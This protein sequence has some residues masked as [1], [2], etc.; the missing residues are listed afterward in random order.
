MSG[1]NF[2]YDCSSLNPEGRIYQVEY[3]EKAVESSST[4]VGVVCSDGIILGTEKIVI[5]KMMISGTDKRVYSI[6]K[7]VGSV[8]NGLTPDGRALMFRAREEAKQYHDNFGIKIP[9]SILAERVAGVCQMNTLY[10]GRRPY[11]ASIIFATHDHL[12]G[13]TLWMVEPSGSCYQYYGCAAGRGR[14]MARNEIE[15]GNFR[16]LTVQQALPKVA[17]LLLQS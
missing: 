17:K 16:E 13:A 10:Y 14:Q 4:T 5:N 2:D 9:G 15:K 11:G 12:K 1:T 8:V 6:T 7:Q 3:A